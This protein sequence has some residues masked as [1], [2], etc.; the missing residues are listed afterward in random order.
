MFSVGMMTQTAAII[1]TFGDELAFL[2][3]YQGIMLMICIVGCIGS[4]VMGVLDTKFG[5]KKAIICSVLIMSLA[6]ILGAIPNA[7][8]LV[9]S[10]VCLAIFMGASSNFTVSAAAQYWRR[11]DFGSF[12]AVV[13][14]IANIFN[15]AG[16]MVIARLL[17]S[18][19]GYQ[20]IFAVTAIAG[21]VSLICMILFKASHVK[22]VDDKY[23]QTAGKV[24]DD[25]LVGR[26]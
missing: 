23:R 19:M 8:S 26:K 25:A 17:Y 6:G 7:M 18:S 11:E 21:V 2:G 16:P 4:Y 9:V 15:A 24:L 5:T 12:F 13:N 14:P 3:G 1:G 10:L 22:L 20:A